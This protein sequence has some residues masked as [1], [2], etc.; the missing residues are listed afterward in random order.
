VGERVLVSTLLMAASLLGA[1]SQV[2]SDRVNTAIV[3]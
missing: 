2:F 3:R 1:F